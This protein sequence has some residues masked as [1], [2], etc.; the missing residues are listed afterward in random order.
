MSDKELIA[1]LLN[2]VAE[3]LERVSTLEFKNAALETELAWYKSNRNSHNSLLPPNRDI[4]KPTP[5]KC[6]R[7]KSSRNP[8]GQHVHK[9]S[10]LEKVDEVNSVVIHDVSKCQHCDDD[11]LEVLG[12]VIRTAQVFD[13]PRIELKVTAHHK[14]RKCCP[15]M[16]PAHNLSITRYAGLY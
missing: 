11:M 6:K 1:S 8:G 2:Q 15:K 10:R 16:Q 3:L 12:E 7:K 4:H 13:I 14:L 5:P 9:A